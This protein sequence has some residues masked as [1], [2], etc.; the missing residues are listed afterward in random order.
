M[1]EHRRKLAQD[2]RKQVAEKKRLDEERQKAMVEKI[3]LSKE[4]EERRN[5]A[6]DKKRKASE[7]ALEALVQ[8][9]KRTRRM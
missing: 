7:A 3:K 6:R 8:T 4:N 5:I 9:R 1:A 2:R